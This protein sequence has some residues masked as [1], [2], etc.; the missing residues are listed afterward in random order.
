MLKSRIIPLMLLD[1]GRLVK[2]VAFDRLR[3]VG[4]AVKSASVYSDQDADELILLDISRSRRDFEAF[5]S[6]VEQISEVCF[7]PL[8]V[9]GGVQS[10][11]QANRLFASG[12]DK[13]VVNT[14]VFRDPE[15]LWS[16][17]SR[18]G[19]QAVVV[20]IDCR[21][22]DLTGWKLYSNCGR[23]FESVS[24]EQHIKAIESLGVGEILVQSIDR[25][26]S[27]RGLDA[28]LCSFISTISS[29]PMIVG[30]GVGDFDHLKSAF[31]D[32]G[33]TAVA[34]GSL[35]NFSD[36]NPLRAKHYLSNF[37]IPFKKI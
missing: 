2:S 15:L 3:A 16:I 32:L 13:V 19:Q 12:A 26:G 18:Y 33:V 9:G 25:D 7:M 20:S 27:M 11:D 4:N 5:V 8:V 31:L 37:G 17:S 36:S 28:E 21:R 24:L 22:D 23:N 10:V 14:A 6:A 29:T 30:G 1:G 34:V 35:F